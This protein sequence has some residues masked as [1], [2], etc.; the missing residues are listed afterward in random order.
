MTFKGYDIFSSLLPGF[1]FLLAVLNVLG[2]AFDKDMIV[3]Y[4]AIAFLL[5]YMINTISSWLEDFYF[6]TWGGKPSTCLLEGKSIWKV[7]FY[8]STK[9]KVLL[10]GEAS[11]H[12]SPDELF[13][14][15]MRYANGQKDPRI[16]DFNSTYALSRSLLT[17]VFLGSIFLLIQH[18]RDWHYYA[19]LLP[20][21]LVMW[22]RC[23]QRAYYYSKEVLD[24]YLKIKTP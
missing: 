6:F 3:A 19:I 17:S 15:A 22:L 13:S 9:V 12:T 8:H 7:K 14:I 4:T 18:A 10:V 16:E 1:L 23:K 24:V 2:V 11:S 5:G 20:T 21:L